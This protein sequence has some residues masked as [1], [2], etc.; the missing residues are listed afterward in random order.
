MGVANSSL[1]WVWSL[2]YGAI[3]YL[4]LSTLYTHTDI[5]TLCVYVCVWERERETERDTRREL[6]YRG[7]WFFQWLITF[8]KLIVS[9]WVLS[10][11]WDMFHSSSTRTWG[12]LWKNDGKNEEPEDGD[13]SCEILFHGHD[14]VVIHMNSHHCGA[15]DL[16]KTDAN[17]SCSK[18]CG[19]LQRLHTLLRSFFGGEDR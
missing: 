18:E 2:L 14:I 3:W 5:Y 16:R 6:H 4:E 15:Q 1:N 10:Y 9:D 17:L 12:A 8:N 11:R 13:E 19:D 7:S